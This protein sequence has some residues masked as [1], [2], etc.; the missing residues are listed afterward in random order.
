MS[1]VYSQDIRTRDVSKI[2]KTVDAASFLVGIIQP[3]L[4]K[5]K[6]QKLESPADVHIVINNNQLCSNRSNVNDTISI[7]NHN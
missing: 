3:Y 2:D 1:I 5:N 6:Q 7:H 4:G